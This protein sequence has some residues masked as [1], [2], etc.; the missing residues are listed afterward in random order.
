MLD[1]ILGFFFVFKLVEFF[2]E[3]K[4]SKFFLLFVK[5]IKRRLEGVKKVKV[6]SFVNG[7]L[8]G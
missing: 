7:L 1:G 2:K 4:G 6:D 5:N 3:G 8:K